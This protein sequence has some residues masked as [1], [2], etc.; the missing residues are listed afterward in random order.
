MGAGTGGTLTGIS[1]AIKE[2]NP[3]VKIIAI[4]PEGS[5][6]AQPPEINGPGPEGGQQ[7]EGIGYDFIPRVLDRTLTDGWLKCPDKESYL[8]A[9][10]LMREEGLMCGGS[11]GS[12]FWGAVKY[13]KENNIGK[14]KR[15]VVLLPDNIRNYMTKHLNDD[16]MYERGYISE[17]ECAAGAKSDLIPNT[18]WGQDLKVSDLDLPEAVF[19]NASDTIET[20]IFAFRES[21]YAQFPVK[22]D[23]KGGKITGVVN[24]TTVMKQL[25]KQRI[26]M[27]DPLSS[28]VERELRHVS[29]G[30]SLDELGRILARNR[31]AL[32]E[33]T[34]FVTTTDLLARIQPP[35]A[36]EQ[37]KGAGAKDKAASDTPSGG[38][39]MLGMAA[40]AMIGAAIGAA[41][42][43]VFAKK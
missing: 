32:V 19:L 15:C 24:K 30:T 10:R 8:W 43:F 29:G 21:G 18:D 36:E 40:T 31:F 42:S 9:R 41:A 37:T 5:I 17:A 4:D 16:W 23:T 6:L 14:G 1:R 28:V 2:K 26:T 27:Q 22:D 11:C 13:I 25:V 3:N 33:K 35:A 38:S 39:S 12:A 34:K 7:V 20:A